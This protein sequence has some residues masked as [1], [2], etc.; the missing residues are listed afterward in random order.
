MI[1]IPLGPNEMKIMYTI[2]NGQPTEFWVPAVNQ[3]MR[4]AAYS[5]SLINFMHVSGETHGCLV[6]PLNCRLAVSSAMVSPLESTLMIFGERVSS[7][8]TTPFGRT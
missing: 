8:V 2:N 7:L 1:Q 3:N 5:V 6:A 4:W